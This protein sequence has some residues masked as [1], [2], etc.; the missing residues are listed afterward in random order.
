[1]QGQSL[2]WSVTLLVVLLCNFISD[3]IS[4]TKTRT[5]LQFIAGQK[6][7]LKILFCYAI[8]FI[9]SCLIPLLL[10]TLAI[11]VSVVVLFRI[12]D[13]PPI[14][15]GAWIVGFFVY[16]AASQ[17]AIV[18]LTTSLF[19]F[20]C[21]LIISFL[22]YVVLVVHKGETLRT[23]VVRFLNFESKPNVALGVLAIL[24]FSV[25]YWWAIIFVVI[26][27]SIFHLQIDPI[28]SIFRLVLTLLYYTK[29]VYP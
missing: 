25:I 28:L 26:I 14:S 17:V 18:S 13:V 5:V 11:K 10:T 6:K 16:R 23:A 7:I 29:G 3:F 8:D 24:L 22:N 12:Y 15:L 20:F 19:I 4:F 21:G 2:F 1:M 27:N 9:L